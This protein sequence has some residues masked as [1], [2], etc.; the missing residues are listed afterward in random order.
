MAAKQPNILEKLTAELAA[1]RRQ[2]AE[3]EA[4]AAQ[5]GADEIIVQ[6][7]M[8]HGLSREQALNVLHRQRAHDQ[9]LGLGAGQSQPQS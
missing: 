5:T 2:I 8:R 4:K 9:G 6:E 3:Y 7:K 1:A